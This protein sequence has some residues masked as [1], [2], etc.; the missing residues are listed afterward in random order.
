MEGSHCGFNDAF[1]LGCLRRAHSPY[2]D[3]LL[4]RGVRLM[5]VP[6]AQR[7]GRFCRNNK[8]CAR[9]GAAAESDQRAK[10]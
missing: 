8:L 5:P 7:Q 1:S 10:L 4:R 9:L 2:P 6:C 3:T